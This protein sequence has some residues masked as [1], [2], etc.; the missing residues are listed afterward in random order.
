MKMEYDEGEGNISDG[1]VCY[2]CLNPEDSDK[3]LNYVLEIKK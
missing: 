3:L 1:Y 2:E